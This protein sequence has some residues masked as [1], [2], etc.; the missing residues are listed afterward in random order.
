[1]STWFKMNPCSENWDE[2]ETTND[3]KFCYLCQKNVFDLTKLSDGEVVKKIKTEKN[4]C[5]QMSVEQKTRLENIPQKSLISFPN[6][7]KKCLASLTI[8]NFSAFQSDL[9]AQNTNQK[10][11]IFA[12]K[13]SEKK[14][15]VQEMRT[16]RGKVIDKSDKTP[17]HGVQIWLKS[18]S[19]KRVQTDVNGDFEIHISKDTISDLILFRY[20]GMKSTE[21]LYLREVYFDSFTVRM[22]YAITITGYRIIE[23]RSLTGGVYYTY[24]P[25]YKK[26]W[27]R[28]KRLFM[29]KDE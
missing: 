3:G 10:T 11:E 17:L 21:Y 15:N 1:M 27:F 2:M 26:I 28:F 19:T 23:S 22:D 18:D 8:L 6:W 13:I 5:G 9:L 12:K 16:I 4:F 20:F 7:A 29:R 14:D 24:V 25:K